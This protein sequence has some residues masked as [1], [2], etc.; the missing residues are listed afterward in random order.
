MTGKCSECDG[1]IKIPKDA[2]NGEIVACPDCGLEFE[3]SI[4]SDGKCNL[5]VAE[6]VGED[7]GE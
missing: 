6:V 3:L 5:K 7:W 4:E 1:E 2:V